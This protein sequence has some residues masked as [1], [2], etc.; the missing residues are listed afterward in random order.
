MPKKTK[1]IV[2]HKKVVSKKETGKKAVNALRQAQGKQKKTQAPAKISKAD[3]KKELSE[4]KIAAL[5]KRGK[6]RGFVTYAE[7]LNFFPHIEYN[8]LFLEDLYARL[9]VA[10]VDILEAKELLEIQE[11]P[12]HKKK[13][14]EEYDTSFSTDSV[15]MY[16]KEIG[17][18][19]LLKGE[20]EKDLAKRIEAGDEDAKNKL[21][22]ANLRLVV[23]IAKRYVGRSPSLT[24]LDLIQEGTIG[25]PRAVKNVDGLRG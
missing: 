1:K 13:A 12:D 8:V 6:E 5:M 25:L 4:E 24:M 16:L 19:S 10:G 20:E 9:E 14:K 7:I 18:I 11:K 21:A 17:R 22:Q 23:S 3:I 2:K 15:Q